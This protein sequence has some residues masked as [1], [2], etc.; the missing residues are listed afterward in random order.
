MTTDRKHNLLLLCCHPS[1]HKTRRQSNLSGNSD[2][3][4]MFL[5]KIS[6]VSLLDRSFMCVVY[7][8]PYSWSAAMDAVPYCE[9]KVDIK[10]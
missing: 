4:N 1:V 10:S 6:T 3:T 5:A 2:V 8:T 9:A 7:T